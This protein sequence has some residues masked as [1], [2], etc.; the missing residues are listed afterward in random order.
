MRIHGLFRYI[1]GRITNGIGY[2]RLKRDIGDYS[3]TTNFNNIM[4][5]FSTA[6]EESVSHIVK[7]KGV[8]G[9]YHVQTIINRQQLLDLV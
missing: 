7:V 2:L 9:L 6:S 5:K 3:Q 4:M 1:N 8:G